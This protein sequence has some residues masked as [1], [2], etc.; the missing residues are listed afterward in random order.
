[1]NCD[2]ALIEDFTPGERGLSHHL[3]VALPLAFLGGP[4]QLD[5]D[6]LANRFHRFPEDRVVE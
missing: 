3:A 1:M 2:E 6:T 4:H 5:I